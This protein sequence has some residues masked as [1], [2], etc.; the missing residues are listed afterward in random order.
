MESCEVLVIGGG[1]A[2]SVCAGRLRQAGFDVLLMDREIFPRRKPCAGWITPE[3][4]KAL[5]IDAEE[6]REGRVL[7]D[8][9]SF[10]TGVING[11]SVVV[12][13]GKTVSYGIRR[14]EFDHYLLQRSAVKQ[15]MGESATEM[16][17]RNGEWIVNGHIRAR[18]LV[19]AGGHF[20]PVARR[21]GSKIG[22]E[23][24]VSSQVAE[25]V[26]SPEE[27]RRCRIRPDTPELFFCAD[28]KGYGW[29]IRKGNFLNVGLG[30]VDKV[31]LGRYLKDFCTFVM[32]IR[33]IP[34]RISESF[35][36]HAYRLY[37]SEE[38][39]RCVDDGVLLIGDAAGVANQFSG[40]GILP[41][42]ESALIAAE[43]IIAAKGDYRREHLDS[44]ASQLDH[45]FGGDNLKMPSSPFLSRLYRFIG[46]RLITN[47][48]FARHVVLDRWFLHA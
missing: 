13:Y 25:A 41:A 5:A 31:T 37:G 6:Y 8:F 3:V 44:Y 2:G 45:C 32:R 38:R 23:E 17:R 22:R 10:R 48:Y 29:L 33:N 12:S 39:R 14:S 9:S 26:L 19:G 47:N 36:G 27:V 21:L 43:T 4:F 30:R 15:Y 34:S 35:Q 46:A 24:I 11:E 16:E 42:I 18:L 28:M 40:E 20:C 7:Q 1:P